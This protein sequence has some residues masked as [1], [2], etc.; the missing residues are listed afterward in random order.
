[1]SRDS[2]KTREE[3]IA[4][5]GAQESQ[6]APCP[7]I[8]CDAALFSLIEATSDRA[9]L[10][11][12]QFRVVALNSALAQAVGHKH[13]DILGKDIREFLPDN[14]VASR[15]QQV[16]KVIAS[17]Q[18]VRFVDERAG[19]VL[20]H[21]VSPIFDAAG[22]VS[23]I[24]VIAR[25][26]TEHKRTAQELEIHAKRL[27]T[28]V[29]LSEMADLPLKTTGAIVLEAALSLT[30][31]GIGFL[32]LIGT[33]GDEFLPF[34]YS[35][36]VM[37]A[38]T[39]QDL[40]HLP[41]SDGS[42][43]A[44]AVSSKVPL[45]VNDYAQRHSA[46]KG[47]PEGHVALER[48]LIVPIL[49]QERVVLLAGVGNKESDYTEGDVTQLR[50]LAKG[51]LVHFRARR[52]EEELCAA[53]LATEKASRAK[54]QFLAT[55]SHELR[56]PM[57]AVLGMLQ[58]LEDTQLDVV[59]QDYLKIASTA[60]RR[61]VALVNDLLDFSKLLGG[62]LRVK[63]APF[64]LS[65]L[66]GSV[67]DRFQA[68]AGQKG[69]ELSFS[70]APSTPP[71]LRGDTGRLS[72]ILSKL[73]EN[74]LKFTERGSV[75]VNIW[76]EPESKTALEGNERVRIF[77]SVADTGI[78]IEAERLASIFD[79][80]SQ[81]DGS[82]SRQRQGAGF[83]L[84]MAKRLVEIMGGEMAIRSTVGRGTTVSFKVPLE[85]VPSKDL[86]KSARPLAPHPR[87]R[88][89]LVE[90]DNVNKKTAGSILGKLG[91]SVA[92]ANNGAEALDMLA[93]EPFDCVLMDIQ[94]PIM[95]G[96]EATRRLRA[97]GLD[98]RLNQD[99]PVIAVTALAMPGDREIILAA[100]VD[101]Y[102]AK[103]YSI[104][105]LRSALKNIA[106]R[107]VEGEADRAKGLR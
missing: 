60:S 103:P 54:S 84:S 93:A 2:L 86:G 46:R 87:L 18:P 69:L 79:P 27:E 53:Q 73:V 88:I 24:A 37:A 106:P 32:S 15:T 49:E 44:E 97:G 31:S 72:Q 100:G 82:L 56:T 8:T 28:L 89:L 39:R 96:L 105:E 47:L 5:L 3:R 48:F 50:L 94:M 34:V 23:Q 13:E 35:T 101:Q 36:S 26:I 107:S 58:L 45:I 52:K 78:G 83:N 76:N 9:F 61:M 4:A 95:D 11:D 90:D 43:L 67:I 38:C 42:L 66:C 16:L 33:D 64:A 22:N 17:R 10:L 68:L 74:A 51:F 29:R 91:H 63:A 12:T 6:P 71:V 62:K 99:V 75:T 81:V 7:S 25:D 57:N 102:I 14:L 41:L 92:I 85:I 21:I 98:A 1:M 77:C 80:F 59:Q 55:M 30:G 104:E 40:D 65:E 20:D 70:I 19:R